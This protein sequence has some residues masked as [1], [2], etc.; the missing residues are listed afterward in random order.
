[1]KTES[2]RAAKR[3]KRESRIE[4]E[5]TWYC[6]GCKTRHPM[7]EKCPIPRL[8]ARMTNRMNA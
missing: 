4:K 6:A 8:F 5:T 7:K 1:M 3:K 2:Q